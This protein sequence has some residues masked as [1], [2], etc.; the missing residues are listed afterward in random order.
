[1]VNMQSQIGAI[2]AVA[3]PVY[4]NIVITSLEEEIKIREA[5]SKQ[6]IEE[7]LLDE[8]FL[9]EEIG[10]RDLIVP[11]GSLAYAVT[12]T[13]SN[14]DVPGPVLA[15]ILTGPF[16][17]YKAIGGFAMHDTYLVMEFSKVVMGAEEYNVSGYA[18]DPGTTLPALSD[19]VNMHY[20]NRFFLPFAASFVASLGEAI[21]ETKTEVNVSDG[22][23]TETSEPKRTTEELW[24]A[25][26]D[27]GG[28]LE[29]FIGE[30]VRSGPTVRVF[31]GSELGILFLEAVYKD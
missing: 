31:A 21:G 24:T 29:E 28:V 12:L 13:E 19:D 1:M 20:F 11:A 18:L 4:S 10:Q 25:V 5:S 14:S 8:N 16:K 23:V 27:A 6:E 22:V 3:E 9:S 15:K 30:Q 17:G 2:V 26:G 7:S